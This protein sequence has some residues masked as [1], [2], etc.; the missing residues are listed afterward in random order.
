[1][2]IMKTEIYKVA[3][4][5]KIT[6]GEINLIMR[7]GKWKYYDDRANGIIA[8]HMADLTRDEADDLVDRL[9]VVSEVEDG[10]SNWYL[11]HPD[12]EYVYVD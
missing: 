10:E 9:N 8:F 1:M 4:G 3:Y 11:G 12:E 6:M 7:A 5:G 2:R